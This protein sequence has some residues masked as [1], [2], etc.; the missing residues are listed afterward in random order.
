MFLI[1]FPWYNNS[2][3]KIGID[4][5]PNKLRVTIPQLRDGKTWCEIKHYNFYTLITPYL[6]KISPPPFPHSAGKYL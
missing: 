5:L 3:R 4:T 6:G 1:L 2:Y